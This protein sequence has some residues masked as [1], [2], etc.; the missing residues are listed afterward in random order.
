MKKVAIKRLSRYVSSGAFRK[1]KYDE[2]FVQCKLCLCMWLV[3]TRNSLPF[4]DTAMF[5]NWKCVARSREFLFWID[6][7]IF[8]EYYLCESANKIISKFQL[9]INLLF[10]TNVDGIL[11]W[12]EC[13]FVI[14]FSPWVFLKTSFC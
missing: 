3:Q 8:K 9:N 11:F 1:T 5:K 2:I 13:E 6:Y 12:I 10:S 4:Q 14:F 7:N